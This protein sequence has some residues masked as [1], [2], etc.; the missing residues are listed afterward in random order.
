[1]NKSIKDNIRVAIQGFSGSFHEKAAQ[2]YFNETL[3]F[4]YCN[5][6]SEVVKASEDS[7]LSDGGLMAIENSIAGTILPNYQLLRNS[8]LSIVG[9]VYLQIGQQLMALPGQTISD[10]KEIHSHHM[11]IKQCEEFLKKHP[12][13]KLVET[14]DTALSAKKI[15]N[16]HLKGVA[17][18]AGE[19][20][21]KIYDLEIIAPNI[22]TVKNNF[23]R[24][25]VINPEQR[26]NHE[27]NKASLLFSLV[28]EPK[29]LSDVLITIGE[30]DFNISK[31]QS[32][33]II[34]QEWSYY[35]VVDIEFDEIK[36]L[37]NLI[38]EL[39]HKTSSLRL[40]GS[41][42]KGITI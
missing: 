22:E 17:A 27:A 32:F 25:L 34:E 40:L 19:Q 36:E 2:H 33:P 15:K 9:E 4:V 41:Y 10:I 28:H 35:F 26:D 14:E 6:F 18:I 24:F 20:A 29:S 13:I 1:M 11:A 23:T 3:S 8:A 39:K 21:A 37:Y 16:E 31:I 42:K 12:N 30:Y 5:T 7:E 38:E